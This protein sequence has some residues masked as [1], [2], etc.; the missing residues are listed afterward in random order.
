M[1]DPTDERKSTRAIRATNTLL[2]NDPDFTIAV[3]PIG[4]GLTIARRHTPLDA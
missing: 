1:A 4:D 3:V 2:R